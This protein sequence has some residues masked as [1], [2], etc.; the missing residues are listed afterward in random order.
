MQDEDWLVEETGTPD[1][2]W[3]SV[4]IKRSL[5]QDLVQRGKTASSTNV[6]ST[7]R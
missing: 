7:S 1:S 2:V 5:N 3:G 4:V 6:T